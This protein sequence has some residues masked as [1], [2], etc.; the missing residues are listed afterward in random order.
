LYY[1]ISSNIGQSIGPYVPE[2]EGNINIS[3]REVAPGNTHITWT[4]Y[5]DWG[6]NNMPYLIKGGQDRASHIAWKPSTIPNTTATG[7]LSQNLNGHFAVR[8]DGVNKRI[9]DAY[10]ATFPN[11][12]VPVALK[13]KYFYYTVNDKNGIQTY[14]SATLNNLKYHI[15]PRHGWT[16]DYWGEQKQIF[17]TIATGFMIPDVNSADINKWFGVRVDEKNAGII[18]D[19]LQSISPLPPGWEQ[20]REPS[21]V[22]YYKKDNVTQYD[23][24]PPLPL[25]SGWVRKLDTNKKFFYLN[26]TKWQYEYPLPTQPVA[27]ATTPTTTQPTKVAATPSVT[28]TPVEYYYK[29]GDGDFPYDVANEALKNAIKSVCPNDNSTCHI[30]LVRT[31]PK[32]QA[33]IIEYNAKIKNK[34]KGGAKNK[35]KHRR[36]KRRTSSKSHRM[37]RRTSQRMRA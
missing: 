20:L 1:F 8:V 15:A 13:P 12:P 33:N 32:E 21:G 6:P 31:D 25:P 5:V 30:E 34:T 18:M 27:A 2:S 23:R 14:T 3:A 9:I 7:W 22:V 11:P 36:T 10:N 24:P 37:R 17:N 28:V 26:G 16:G 19:Y 35:K 29:V 4:P